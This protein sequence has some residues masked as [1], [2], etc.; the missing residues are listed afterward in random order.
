[1]A[2]VSPIELQ[3][4]LKGANY[5]SSRDDLMRCAEN[6]GADQTIMDELSHLPSQDFENPSEVQK[7]VFH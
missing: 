1:M 5:P 4:A 2:D 6:N 7:A 3:M